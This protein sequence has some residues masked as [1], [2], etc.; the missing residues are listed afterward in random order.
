MKLKTQEKI[1]SIELYTYLLLFISTNLITKDTNI[2]ILK[3]LHELLEENNINLE[4]LKEIASSIYSTSI[5]L[6]FRTQTLTKEYKELNSLYNELLENTAEFYKE[7]GLNNPV[8]IFAIFVFMYRSGYFSYNK[9]F[10][11]STNMKD[12][13]KLNGIDV[14]RGKGVC[15]SI[16]SMLTD[17]YRK[18]GMNSSNL[19]VRA[20]DESIKN[21]QKLGPIKLEKEPS[22]K[23]FVKVVTTITKYI[24]LSNHLITTVESDGINY[25]FDPTNDGYLYSGEKD[26]LIIPNRNEYMNNYSLGLIT[27]LLNLLGA[28][29]NGIN[30]FKKIDQLDLPNLKEEYYE[31]TYNKTIE[32]Y[33][34]NTDIFKKFYEYNKEIINKIYEISNEQSSYIKRLF[35]INPK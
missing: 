34:K 35:P 18:M 4:L 16:S 17:I 23:R 1:R 9:E 8:E 15:R 29:N 19:T 30:I 24:P 10:K 2:E 28:Y 3:Q 21:L 26:R 32:N 5:T 14:I 22:S 33:T 6:N 31:L 13:A 7:L 20:N 25:I 27:T 12:F 11:Y